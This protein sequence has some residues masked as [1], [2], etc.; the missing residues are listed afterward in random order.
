MRTRRQPHFITAGL[1]AAVAVAIA[2]TGSVA[3]TDRVITVQP[4]D[5]L[6]GIAARNGVTVD[7]LVALNGIANPNRIF[8]GQR[9]KV[10]SAPPA[11]HPAPQQAVLRTHRVAFGENLTWIARRHGTTI[12]AIAAANGISNPSY[13]RT[14]QVLVIPSGGVPS[15]AGGSAQPTG[16]PAPQQ[17]VLRTH[18]V[19]F[20][21]NL[22]WIAR[23]HGTTIAAI[24]AANGISNPS[25][26]RTGQV[27][28]IPG[29]APSRAAVTAPAGG[30]GMPA[31][32]AALVAK[33]QDVRD[34]IVAEANRQGVPPAFA[35]AV[36]WQESGW[37][38][39]VVSSAGAIG[40]MQ[41]LPATGEWV[42]GVMLGEQV[43]LHDAASNVRAGVRLLRH[44]LDRYG[45]RS[46][47]LAAYYQGQ[48][49]TDRHGIYPVSRPYIASILR[50]EELFS[51]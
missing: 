25:Y 17:A 2:F 27:L 19:A 37:Q 41:L 32:M 8:A 46:L 51:R 38:Q 3:A 21:E 29:G 20:G 31:S 18:R 12:A 6:S 39:G 23:R 43:N 7:D 49:A 4:G 13:I 44:Y 33:R 47:A 28:V 9:L 15:A 48:A 36:A 30:S 1:A 14:G 45:D 40:V 16:H 24:A 22:T 35:L 10:G 42:G 5:T 50:L 34:L 26:I 11:G